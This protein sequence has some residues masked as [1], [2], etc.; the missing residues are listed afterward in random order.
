M[1]NSHSQA[2]DFRRVRRNL[3]TAALALLTAS[4]AF[5]QGSPAW[6]AKA[7]TLIVPF[8]PGGIAD[9]TARAVAQSMAKSLGQPIVVDN[10][11][12]AGSIVA[13]QAVANAAPDGYTVL[14]M[15]NSNAVSEGLFKKLPFNLT[16]DFAPVG[17]LGFFDLAAFVDNG[18][19]FK[20]LAEVIAYAKANPG[21]LTIGT[22]SVGS[23]QHL[24]AELFKTLG[25]HRRGDRAVQGLL[26][27]ADGAARRRDRRRLRD[28]RAVPVA[29]DRPYA[30]RAGGDLGQALPD[31]GRRAD[32]AGI[33]RAWLRRGVVE[34]AGGAGEDAGP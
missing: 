33:R 29:G 5:A 15:S 7:I 3:L 14:L 2:C 16:R 10:R 20:T 1:T 4:T 25:R 27:G 9:I 11:P 24:S 23:T 32:G 18:S 31:A 8:A 26:R 34:R 6:P 30:A 28:P 12:S 22:I 19:R 21:K 13:S 17:M